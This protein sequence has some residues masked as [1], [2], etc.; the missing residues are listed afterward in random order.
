MLSI[1]TAVVRR[2]RPATTKST[3]RRAGKSRTQ[4]IPRMASIAIRTPNPPKPEPK[5]SARTDAA[6][7]LRTCTAII[8]RTRGSRSART[9]AKGPRSIIGAARQKAAAPTISGESVK[10]SASQPRITRSIQR[11]VLAQSPASHRSR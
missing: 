7:T 4:A 3:V 8:T 5:T 10:A 1:E 6:A 2:S 11:A 9:P